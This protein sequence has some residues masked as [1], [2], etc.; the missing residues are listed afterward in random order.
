MAGGVSEASCIDAA[1][2]LA[3]GQPTGWP[4]AAKG[5][6]DDGMAQPSVA[7]IAGADEATPRRRQR[8]TKIAAG[9]TCRQLGIPRPAYRFSLD[10]GEQA[11]SRPQRAARRTGSAH[12][13]FPTDR[14]TLGAGPTPSR[15]T[16][17]T[18][19]ARRTGA[20]QTSKFCL[21]YRRSPASDEQ[22]RST[23]TFSPAYRRGRPQR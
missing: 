23:T 12:T 2:A 19:A 3:I 15:Q 10:H 21:A 20:V 1:M 5:K 17:C 9:S 22:T 14:Q 4:Q 18:D 6:E 8:Q 13:L 16:R 11:Q 7:P